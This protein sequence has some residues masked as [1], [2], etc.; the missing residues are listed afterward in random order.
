MRQLERTMLIRYKLACDNLLFVIVD[1]IKDIPDP[2]R[3]EEDLTCKQVIAGR[4]IDIRA[5][6][7]ET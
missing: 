4:E 5:I 3:I 2:R 6:V 7:C 1:S